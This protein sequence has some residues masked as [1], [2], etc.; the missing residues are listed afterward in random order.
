MPVHPRTLYGHVQGPNLIHELVLYSRLYYYFVAIHIFMRP[1]SDESR[2]GG[3]IL[4]AVDKKL[5][6]RKTDLV[7]FRREGVLL[8]PFLSFL[9]DKNFHNKF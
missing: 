2:G 9:R 1:R 3:P 8:C 4:G 7:R 5:S 6:S